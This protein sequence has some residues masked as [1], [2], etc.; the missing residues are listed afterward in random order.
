MCF[1]LSLSAEQAALAIEKSEVRQKQLLEL[2]KQIKEN[3][4]NRL[5]K[6]MATIEIEKEYLHEAEIFEEKL[7]IKENLERQK[8]IEHYKEL[9]DI[10]E[11]RKSHAEW[12]VNRLKLDEKR[13]L[14]LTE[15]ENA[16]KKEL[17]EFVPP[18]SPTSESVMMISQTSLEEVV[19]PSPAQTTIDSVMMISQTSE[20]EPEV[21]VTNVNYD[22][23]MNIV[24]LKKSNSDYFNANSDAM[25]DFHKNKLKVLGSDATNFWSD[26][27]ITNTLIESQIILNREISRDDNLNQNLTEGQRNKIKG[28]SHEKNLEVGELTNLSKNRKKVSSP[29]KSNLNLDLTGSDRRR[30]KNRN[31]NSQIDISTPDTPMSTCSEIGIDVDNGNVTEPLKLDTKKANEEKIPKRCGIPDTA[32]LA[33]KTPLSGLNNSEVITKDGF[34]FPSEFKQTTDFFLNLPSSDSTDSILKNFED[35]RSEVNFFELQRSEN[36]IN[37]FLEEDKEKLTREELQSLNMTPLSH[38]LQKSITIPLHAH[39]EVINNEILKIYLE[40]LDIIGHFK[41]LR[42]YFFLMD[43]EFGSYVCDGLI[44]KLERGSRPPE[45]LNYHTLHL[46]LENALGSSIIGNDKNAERLSFI[47]DQMPEE[48]FDLNSANVLNMLSLSYEVSWPLNL[49]LNPETIEQYTNVFK[50]LLKVRRI[51][52][53]L[54][55]TFHDLKMVAK[56]HGRTILRSPQYNYVQQI[57]HKLSHFVHALQNHITSN[58]LQAAWKV[59]KEDLK[60]SKTMEQL[61]RKHTHY[62]KKILFLCM[63]NKKSVEFYNTIED[64]FKVVLKFY[65]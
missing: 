41:S 29:L 30:N 63:L 14:F 31:Q 33:K 10:V 28:M 50:Y 53:V 48:K 38:F 23:E 27:T 52:W 26:P 15:D 56:E 20:V 21:E 64:I 1:F 16:W 24:P 42:N 2:R 55:E 13:R 58:A 11:S 62:V 5:A 39:M 32:L 8:R 4:E 34:K 12:K 60:G 18:P 37:D 57:R 61:Y 17:E 45:L 36:P 51:S 46:I 19:D 59:F 43:G 65:R 54:E 25:D 3:E 7:L 40:D 22:N 35:K 9:N 6:K 47:V 44:R 49:I